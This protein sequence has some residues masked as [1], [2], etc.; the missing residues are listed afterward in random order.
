MRSTTVASTRP[1]ICFLAWSLLCCLVFLTTTPVF[2]ADGD[3]DGATKQGVSLKILNAKIKEAEADTELDE[4][5]RKALTELY[6]KSVSN[7]ESRASNKAATEEYRKSIE[8]APVETKRLEAEVQDLEQS[9]FD[10][11]PG[12]DD[13][14]PTA[15]IAQALLKARANLSAVDADCNRLKL[16]LEAEQDRLTAARQEL[17]EANSKQSAKS[18]AAEA[19]SLPSESAELKK[20][21]DWYRS[22]RL[23]NLA[24]EIKKLDQEM[25]SHGPRL[26]LLKAQLER[27][28]ITLQHLQAT[29]AAI[30]SILGERRQEDATKALAMAQAAQLA[31][32]GKHPMLVAVAE[33]NAAISEELYQLSSKIEDVSKAATDAEQKAKALDDSYRS[34]RQKLDVAGMNRALGKILQDQRAELPNSRHIRSELDKKENLISDIALQQ[35]LFDEKLK[36]LGDMDAAVEKLMEPLA[37]E[38]DGEPVDREALATEL[39]TL[40]DQRLLLYKKISGISAAYLQALSDLE[41]AKRRLLDMAERYDAFLGERLLWVRSAPGPSFDS[42]LSFYGESARYF[43]LASWQKALGLIFQLDR[44]SVV[45]LV[46][47]LTAIVLRWRRRELLR[48][49]HDS[50]KHLGNPVSDRYGYT[51]E[52]FFITLLLSAPG[53]L[54]L[55]AVGVKLKFAI[56]HNA[57]SQALAQALLWVSQSWFFI[58]VFHQVCRSDGLA[59]RHFRWHRQVLAPLRK[60][61]SLLMVSFLPVS[62]TTMLLASLDSS[63]MEWGVVRLGLLVSM[64]LFALFFLRLLSARGGVMQAMVKL[65]PGVLLVRWRVFWL[66]LSVLIPVVLAGLAATGYVYT[67]ITLMGSFVE[68][69]WVVILVILVH[70]LCIRWL[71][72]T[73]VQLNYQA[74]QEERKKQF[75]EMF[76]SRGANPEAAE[77]HDEPEVDLAHLG[78]DSIRLV[79][80]LAGFLGTVG[81]L[82]VWSDVLPALGYLD[83]LALWHY[84]GTENGEA[85]IIAVSLADLGTA[86]LAI[87]ITILI[88]RNL[89]SLLELFM[90]QVSSLSASDRY[91]TVTLTRYFVLG[92]GVFIVAGMLGIRWSQFQWLAAA[93]G[94]GIGFGLQEIVANFISGLI[95][96][97]ER[98][99]RVGD[100]VTVG[101]VDGI[102][103]RIRI[104]ATTILTWDRQELLVPNK[105]FITG[106]LLNWSLSDQVSRLLIE[107]GVAYGSDVAQAMSIIAKA[108]EDH[109]KVLEDPSPFVTFEGFG[110]NTL[111]LKL[112]CYLDDM[113]IRL[114]TTSDLHEAINSAFS[115][116]GIVIAFPQRDIHF[117]ADSALNIRLSTDKPIPDRP[118]TP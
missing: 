16:Q 55:G 9:V 53:P 26:E 62:F 54:L 10:P 79:N 5:S 90:L 58:Q 113:N 35:L 110:D 43:S 114:S 60:D 92:V 33:E 83:N 91:T 25:L 52:A 7:L 2:A 104:R 38:Y 44:F 72:M 70:Q 82:L 36:E 14:T 13:K 3:G 47:V 29:V 34:V 97:F 28:K 20:A 87:G 17:A 77:V 1:G 56:D 18:A 80:I 116:A 115:E 40:L 49:L 24:A 103:S 99:I 59:Q 12:F 105:E 8:T 46:G 63:G 32:E 48:R 64:A 65:D 69:F 57:L 4:E 67:A 107:V 76:A 41:Y 45:L 95:I 84:S 88:Y 30:E 11:D 23:L 73:S 109:P 102:V 101:D 66:V 21:R 85:A 75:Q 93:L 78:R 71:R 108:A 74:L 86:I 39:T 50:N 81:L 106:T 22:T 19:G 27:R 51:M 6:R 89:P 118:E 98:P 68:T 42:M 117:D 31:A 111:N 15:D 37:D 94:V 112:R 96:L 100:R 61:L